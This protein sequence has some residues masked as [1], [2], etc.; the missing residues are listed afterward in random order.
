MDAVWRS[1]RSSNG[2]DG[3]EPRSNERGGVATS[4][5]SGGDGAE[6]CD[7]REPAVNVPGCARV[8]P[9]ID[10]RRHNAAF[11][12]D[13]LSIT[14]TS[15]CG[16]RS[17]RIAC[18][19]RANASW[20]PCRVAR[21]RS[22]SWEILVRLG[23]RGRRP[24]TSASA[25][26]STRTSPASTRASSASRLGRPLWRSTRCRPGLHDPP[27]RERHPSGAVWRVRTVEAPPLQ[28]GRD[29]SRLRG[30]RHRPQPSTTKLPSSSAT[31]CAGTP[32]TSVASTRCCRR[33]P[34]SCA[35]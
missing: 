30:G 22:R 31:C 10:V 19:S 13:N 5:I 2:G 11:C 18:S 29:R 33:R 32:A 23:L 7:S 14:A 3:P 34:A 1:A 15:R 6:P 35:R 25:S 17:I 8:R 24:S 4:T 21:T 9:V 27:S 16:E 28:L 26:A 20:S 12:K